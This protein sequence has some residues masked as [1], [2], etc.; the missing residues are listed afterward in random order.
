MKP[1]RFADGLELPAEAVT[2]TFAFVARRG[3]GK[4]YAAGV[5]VEGLLDVGA[6]VAVIDPVGVWWG[7]R[8]SADGRVP[9]YPIL[10]LGGRRGDLPLAP[11]AGAAV[12]RVLCERQIPAELLQGTHR[13]QGQGFVRHHGGSIGY[14]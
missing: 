13:G 7:L 4:T 14:I 9:A 2:E 12:A 5:L 3:A 1:I 11:T 6:P 8:L 10:V